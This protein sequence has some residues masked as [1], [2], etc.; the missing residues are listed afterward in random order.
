MQPFKID[1]DGDRKQLMWWPYIN[2]SHL[3]HY[4]E[5]TYS[6]YVGELNFLL[7]FL[8]VQTI[9]EPLYY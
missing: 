1:A 5:I 6:L 9:A 3:G 7:R 4:N 2:S 8:L